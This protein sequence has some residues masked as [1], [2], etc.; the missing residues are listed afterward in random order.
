MCAYN[1]KFLPG[2][3]T[4]HFQIREYLATVFETIKFKIQGGLVKTCK[5]FLELA[6]VWNMLY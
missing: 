4:C 2:K 6:I 3:D 5:P 1:T